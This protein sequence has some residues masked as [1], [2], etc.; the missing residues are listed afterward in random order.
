MSSSR[1]LS[2]FPHLRAFR[3]DVG[4]GRDGR[5]HPRPPS[6]APIRALSAL[7]YARDARAEHLS[8][9]DAR[10]ALRRPALDSARA[11]APLRVCQRRLSAAH[12]RRTVPR[13]R[14]PAGTPDRIGSAARCSRWGSPSVAEQAP[15]SPGSWRCRSRARSCSISSAKRHFRRSIRPAS[16]G[17]TTGHGG[18]AIAM[19]R[20][21]ATWSGTVQWSCCRIAQRR[22][23]PLGCR[24]S[25]DRDHRAR[26]RRPVRRRC[27]PRCPRSD[28]SR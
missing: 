7:S 10:P 22:R 8:A 24:G 28:P 27:E 5:H 14:R 11:G 19:A 17:S 21:S 26:S 3:L 13:S 4:A 16:S 2:L 25:A 20:S 12:L 15:A 1:L 6:A 23:S 9:H 18:A